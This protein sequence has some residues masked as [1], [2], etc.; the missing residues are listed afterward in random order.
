MT[1]LQKFQAIQAICPNVGISLTM[2]KDP[3]WVMTRAPDIRKEHTIRGLGVWSDSPE[4]CIDDSWEVISKA[5]CL[6]VHDGEEYHY[7]RWHG[8]MWK[9]AYIPK[10]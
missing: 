7:Y 1:T 2:T 4:E 10:D 6:S 9:Y 8:F 5:E 3:K